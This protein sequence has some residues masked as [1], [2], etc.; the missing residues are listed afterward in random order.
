MRRYE[1]GEIVYIKEIG[2]SDEYRREYKRVHGKKCEYELTPFCGDMWR[3]QGQTTKI[4]SV[5]D[6][7]DGFVYEIEAD[8]GRFFWDA[9]MLEGVEQDFDIDLSNAEVLI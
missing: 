9:V 5:F 1:I 3:Y 6:E 2:D 7:G 4:T 8:Y